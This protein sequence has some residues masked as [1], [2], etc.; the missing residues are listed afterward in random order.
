[1]GS[2]ARKL[3]ALLVDLFGPIPGRSNRG[4]KTS[5]DTIEGRASMS[6]QRTHD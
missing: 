1:V 2:A 6:M 3:A 4:F 5:G